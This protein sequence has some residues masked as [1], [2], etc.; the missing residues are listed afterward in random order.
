MTRWDEQYR[1]GKGLR[2]YPCEAL[3]RFVGQRWAEKLPAEWIAEVGCGNGANLWFL[4][5]QGFSVTGFDSSE[6]GLE[7]AKELLCR[8]NQVAQLQVA[9]MRSLPLSDDCL[10]GLVDVMASQHLSEED[11]VV[12][13]REFRRVLKGG[14]WLFLHHLSAETKGYDRIFP[15]S[16]PA[17]L[18]HMQPLCLAL[19]NAGFSVRPMESTARMYHSGD[20]ATYWTIEAVAT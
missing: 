18:A 16:P 15:G 17:W 11:H 1:S 19:N 4:A 7:L 8:R 6:R 2:W 13:Y 5:E 9:D 3:V 12:A 10:D 14:A 20:V